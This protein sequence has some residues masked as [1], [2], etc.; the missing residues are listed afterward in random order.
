MKKVLAAFAV[1]AIGAIALAVPAHAVETSAPDCKTVTSNITN[2]PDSAV[3]GFDWALDTFTRE[4]QVCHVPADVTTKTVEVKSW[5]YKATGGDNGT[6]K[7]QGI[8]SPIAG[9]AMVAN[10]TGTFV[11]EFS[12]TFTAP[13]EWGGFGD[14][15]VK[16]SNEFSTSEWLSKLWKI[17]GYQPNEDFVWQ[18]VYKR[19]GEE[20]KQASTGHTGDIFGAPCASP[21]PSTSVSAS[22]TPSRSTAVPVAAPVGSLP[23]TGSKIPVILGIG[24]VLAAI[25][26]GLLYASRKRN[27]KF[28]A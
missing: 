4:V 23:V 27:T 25:G 8:K 24:A 1:G 19:C 16:N 2:R 17:G 13:A 28:V 18:W 20:M 10:A 21:S 12:L 3:G 11:G 5:Q 26:G 9:A 22:A 14:S 15:V 7:T 6:F